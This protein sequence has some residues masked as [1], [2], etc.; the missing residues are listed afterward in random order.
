MELKIILEQANYKKGI[1]HLK[2][3]LD[4]S[5][6]E[7]MQ[8]NE[9]ERIGSDQ[10]EMGVG[11]ILNSVTSIIHAAEKPLVELV[12]CLKKYVDNYRTTIRIPQNSGKDIVLEHGRS[13]TPEQLKDIVV[14]I[15]QNNSQN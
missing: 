11:E 15:L 2:E 6:I 10:N 12:M 4:R 8:I 7:G 9:V 5:G 14:A 3:Q 13:M 1:I